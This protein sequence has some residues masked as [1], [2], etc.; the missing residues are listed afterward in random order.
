MIVSN[1]TQWLMI[2]CQI[3]ETFGDIGDTDPKHTD[4]KRV[5]VGLVIYGD[6]NLVGFV[7]VELVDLIRPAIGP[8]RLGASLDTVFDLDINKRLGAAAEAARR[9]VV[10]ICY[11]VNA[12]R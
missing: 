1:L 4:R 7:D 12:Q 11:S 9:C 2:C 8:G 10:D 3:E 5:F 6:F